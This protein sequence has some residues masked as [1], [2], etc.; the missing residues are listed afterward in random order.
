MVL[1]SAVAAMALIAM[2]GCARVSTQHV[3]NSSD[4]LPRPELILVDYQVSRDDVELD[5]AIGSRLKR[6]MNGRPEGGDQARGRAGS[7]P[8]ADP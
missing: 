7:E 4:R 1:G 8:R 5:G 6:A 2:A 3:E